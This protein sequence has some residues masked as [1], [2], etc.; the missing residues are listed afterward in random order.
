MKNFVKLENLVIKKWNRLDSRRN[1]ERGE[2]MR[3]LRAKGNFIDDW[4]VHE[5][6]MNSKGFMGNFELRQKY[7]E[8]K[9]KVLK[10]NED[11]EMKNDKGE[12]IDTIEKLNKIAEEYIVDKETL[13]KAMEKVE[14]NQNQ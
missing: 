10:L 1:V 6:E 12:I 4:V 13:R 11:I 5:K 7:E 8:A 9:R 2:E 3:G 14:Q